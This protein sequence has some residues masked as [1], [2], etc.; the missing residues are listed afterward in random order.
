MPNNEDTAPS[1]YVLGEMAA[2][3]RSIDKNVTAIRSEIGD[4]IRRLGVLENDVTTLQA[5]RG[6]LLPQYHAH[7]QKV[8]ELVTWRSQID[9]GANVAKGG[10]NIFK[11]I[12][13]VILAVGLFIAGQIWSDYRVANQ[14][15]PQA[16]AAN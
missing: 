11:S 5:E 7:V 2:T 9:G 3:V 4:I 10:A 6:A 1:G 15:Q 13:G 16:V 14:Q 8:D 12:L